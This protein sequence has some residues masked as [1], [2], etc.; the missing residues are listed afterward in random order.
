MKRKTFRSW[1]EIER[2][3]LPETWAKHQA[4]TPLERAYDRLE[5]LK[6]EIRQLEAEEELKALNE[7]VHVIQ[8][9]QHD[10]G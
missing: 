4:M 5:E 7:K 10:E 8:E 6:R 1:D 2:E 3:Y 9:V